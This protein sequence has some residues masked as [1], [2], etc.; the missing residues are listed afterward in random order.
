MKGYNQDKQRTVLNIQTKTMTDIIKYYSIVLLLLVVIDT[1]AQD[2][3]WTVNY[4]DFQNTM[5][6]IVAISDECVPSADANDI[7]AAF[8]ITGQIRG[9]EPTIVGNNAFLTIG[10]NGAGEMIYFKVYD[11]S[12]NAVY[13]IYNTSISF[14]GDSNIGTV[15]EPFILNFDSNP[16][17]ASAGPD[18]EIFNM[19]TTTL[20][21]SGTGSWSI[22][23]GEGGSFLD[24]SSA[25]TV[26]NGV[27][28]TKYILAWTLDNAAGCIGETDEVVIYFVIPADENITLTCTDGLDNDGDGLTDCDDPDCGKPDVTDVVVVQPTPIDC[29]STQSDGSI[30]IIQTGADSFSIDMGENYQLMN[31]FSGLTTGTYNVLLKSNAQ[32]CILNIERELEN[33]IDPIKDVLGIKLTGPTVLCKGSEAVKFEIDQPNL[34]VLN[35]TYTGSDVTIVKDG[36]AGLVSF[37][38]NATEGDIV[39]TMSSTCSVHSDTLGIVFANDFLCSFSN[40]PPSISISTGVIESAMSPQVYRAGIDLISNAQLSNKNFEFTAGNSLQFETGFSIDQGLSFI[41]GIQSCTN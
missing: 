8:D 4:A 30:T 38:S 10:S 6:A 12:T 31:A 15:P 40:C 21:A 32:G 28:A 29:N 22:V 7:V 36:D 1:N 18:Q 27:I 25:T 5:T 19:T 26:F 33:L 39:A 9:V 35:W 34:S 41:A 14:L 24:A 3:N 2:P 11:A 37:G 20:A 17:G 23:E 16:T 13:N